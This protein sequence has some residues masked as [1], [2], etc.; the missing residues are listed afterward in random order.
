[1]YT[2]T[3]FR[4]CPHS[5]S[6][7]L[8]LGELELEADLVEEFPWEWREEFLAI[9]PAG[10]LPVLQTPDGVVLCGVYSVSEY[11]AEELKDG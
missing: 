10:E 3:H 2:L 5:R 6:I 9:N 11:L 4:L 7:R 1:M 8:A